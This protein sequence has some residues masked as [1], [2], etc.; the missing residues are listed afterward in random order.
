MRQEGNTQTEPAICSETAESSPFICQ[1]KLAL[2]AAAGARFM[3]TTAFGF[4]LIK[5]RLETFLHLW[6]W[7]FLRLCRGPACGCAE[8]AEAICFTLRTLPIIK[9]KT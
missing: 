4:E 5:G 2:Q 3:L 1:H 9:S 6:T 8:A 7:P